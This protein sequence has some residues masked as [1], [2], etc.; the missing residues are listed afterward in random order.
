M[1]LTLLNDKVVYKV[2]LL[3]SQIPGRGYKI[4][5]LKNSLK[6]NNSSLYKALDKLKFY[7]VLE[8]KKTIYKLNFSNPK[9]QKVLDI[10][11]EDIKHLKGINP[12]ILP[13]LFELLD[14]VD[15]TTTIS[16]V[17]LFGS[18]VKRTEN[19]RSDIDIVIISS[20]N[21][22]LFEVTNI[23]QEKY[24]KKIEFHYFLESEFKN[25]SRLIQEIQRD[26]VE[27]I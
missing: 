17:I 4:G 13:I 2:L 12:T 1:I 26:G 27:L 14:M 18:Y 23:L 24:D 21:I 9:T 22:D 10:V 7:R 15:T 5:E 19:S 11:K 8:Q 20:E 3:I 25:S 6:M 16:Q